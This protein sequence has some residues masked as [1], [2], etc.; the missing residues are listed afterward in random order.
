MHTYIQMTTQKP[1]IDTI[2][3]KYSICFSFVSLIFSSYGVNI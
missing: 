3:F 1:W 2:K